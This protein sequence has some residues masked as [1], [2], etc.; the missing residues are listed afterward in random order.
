MIAMGRSNEG[1]RKCLFNYTNDIIEN[2]KIK[3]LDVWSR[4]H[5]V[6]GWVALS[7]CHKVLNATLWTEY[8]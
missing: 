2:I 8:L 5:F 7:Q 4:W 1:V 6:H 3:N